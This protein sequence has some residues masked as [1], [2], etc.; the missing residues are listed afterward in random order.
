MK[1]MVIGYDYKFEIQ[2]ALC[3]GEKV[4]LIFCPVIF[5]FVETGWLK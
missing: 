2:C 1:G 3:V 5:Q 4:W